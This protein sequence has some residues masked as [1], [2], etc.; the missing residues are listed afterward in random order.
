MS[1]VQLPQYLALASSLQQHNF[2][3]SPAEL[4]GLLTGLI[5]GG[6]PFDDKSYLAAVADF[7]NDGQGLSDEAQEV[8]TL[9]FTLASTQLTADELAFSLLL[10][11][12]DAQL[13]ER[14][15]AYSDWASAFL[16]GMGLMNLNAKSL[17]EDVTEA[18]GDLQE[19]AQLGVDEDDDMGEQAQLF[20]QVVEH[21]RMCVMTCFAELGQRPAQGPAS[22]ETLH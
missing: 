19:M 16:T 12:D 9:L 6:H 7:A 22:S 14:A 1:E 15:E 8:V 5:C 3:I 21:T 13:V 4:Q 18:L 17:S 2:P 10:P 11:D 20:E